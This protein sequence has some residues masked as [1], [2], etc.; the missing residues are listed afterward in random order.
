MP[1]GR[2]LTVGRD[3][4][5]VVAI[6]FRLEVSVHH[7][8]HGIRPEAVEVEHDGHVL[9][10]P[11]RSGHVE[12]ESTRDSLEGERLRE[13]AGGMRSRARNGRPRRRR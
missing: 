6:G 12:L 8:L 2:Y 10:T 11:I 5:E 13:L 4:E 3:D 7:L 9:R 1:I